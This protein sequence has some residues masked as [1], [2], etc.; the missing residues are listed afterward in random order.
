VDQN[1]DTLDGIVNPEYYKIASP[2]PQLAVDNV[3]LRYQTTDI[4]ITLFQ[5]GFDFESWAP[6]DSWGVQPTSIAA[7]LALDED[8]AEFEDYQMDVQEK[9]DVP[10]KNVS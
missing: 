7:N 3:S 8:H 9:W 4:S 6:P 2:H 5:K 1:F 10:K